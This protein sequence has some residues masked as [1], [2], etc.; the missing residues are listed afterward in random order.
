MK[1]KIITWIRKQVKQAKAKGVVVGLS[2]GLDS[3]VTVA[4][5]C[6]ALGR[7]KVL[8]LIMPCSSQRKD[9]V[10]AR[11]VVKRLR[12]KIKFI[13]LGPVYKICLK[14]LPKA[15]QLTC[16]NLKA[17]LRMLVLYY[18]ANKL[19]YLVCGTSN[20][21]ELMTGYFTKFGDAAVDILPLGNLLK[22]QVK[23]L[24]RTL[25]IPQS[26]INKTPTA[27]LWPGQTDEGELGISYSQLDDI[28]ARLLGG[29]KQIQPLRLVNKVKTRI[30]ASRHK[31]QP[32]KVCKI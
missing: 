9:L 6:R 28:L 11:L 27:G 19:N 30:K 21:S 5:C 10:D 8:A 12:I 3:A 22:S 13:D 32:P 26:I 23:K 31:R 16:G 20:K 4:L 2:G 15:D 7:N 18:F 14:N 17:R 24:A 29:K 1:Q 25:N